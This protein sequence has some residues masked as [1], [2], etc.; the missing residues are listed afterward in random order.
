MALWKRDSE[1]AEAEPDPGVVS[2]P[3][4]DGRLYA[5]NHRWGAKEQTALFTRLEQLEQSLPSPGATA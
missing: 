5:D 2:I 1:P 3:A 4:A